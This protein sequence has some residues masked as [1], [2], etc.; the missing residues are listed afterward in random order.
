MQGTKKLLIDHYNCYNKIK[1]EVLQLATTRNTNYGHWKSY[2]LLAMA[3]NTNYGSLKVATCCGCTGSG[4]TGM[5]PVSPTG[6]PSGDFDMSTVPGDLQSINGHTVR[7]FNGVVKSDQDKCDYRFL[8]LENGLQALLISEPGLDKASAALDVHVGNFY[9]PEDIPGLAHFLEHLLFMGT[10]KYPD[11]NEYGKYLSAH[12]GHSN[13]FTAQEHTN[14]FFDVVSDHL[15]GALDRFAQF[16]ISPLFNP[17]GTERE[18]LAVDSEHKKNVLNDHWRIAQLEK[19]LS[20]HSHPYSHFGTGSLKTLKEGP[21]SRGIDIRSVLIEFYG[22]HY[23]SNLMKLVVFGKNPLDELQ[24]MVVEKFSAVGNRNFALR[25]WPGMPLDERHFGKL[26]NVRTVKEMRS[27]HVSWQLPDMKKYKLEKPGHYFSH[28]LGHEGHGSILAL[29][30]AQGWATHLS[31]GADADSRGYTFFEVAIELSSS[32]LDHVEDIVKLIFQYLQL[33]RNS[34]PQKAIFEETKRLEEIEFRF[35]EKGQPSSFA[36]RTSGNMQS[37]APELILKGPRVSMKYDEGLLS[38]MLNHIRG[39]NFRIILATPSPLDAEKV[40]QEKWYKTEY[41]VEPLSEELMKFTQ[42]PTTNP[43]LVLPIPN[44]F[45][46]DALNAKMAA[47]LIP[48]MKPTLIADDGQYRL[49]HKQDD[50]FEMPKGCFQ[51]VVLTPATYSSP[52][53]FVRTYLFIELLRDSMN[54]LLYEAEM[55]GLHFD[56]GQTT[57]GIYLAFCGYDQKLPLLLKEVMNRVMQYKTNPARFAAIKDKYARW[58]KSVIHDNPYGLIAYYLNGLQLEYNWWYWEK[59]AALPLITADSIDAFAAEIFSRA[60]IEGLCHGNY[61]AEEALGIFT[62]LRKILSGTKALPELETANVRVISLEPRQDIIFSPGPIPNSNSAI[63]FYLQI[64][65]VG[66]LRLRT[67]TILFAQIFH[68][69]FFDLLRTKEQLGYI[70]RHQAREK[71]NSIGLRFLVQSE[72]DPVYLDNRIEVFLSNTVEYLTSMDVD[73]YSTHV[74]ALIDRLTA[75]KR[76]MTDE[77][78]VYWMQIIGHQYEFERASV[79]ADYLKNHT[80]EDLLA[81][82]RTHVLRDAPER[83]KLSI[84]LWSDTL[85][86]KRVVAYSELAP[87]VQLFEEPSKLTKAVGLFPLTYSVDDIGKEAVMGA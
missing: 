71:G 17:S 13:A 82:I 83:R 28:L 56:I 48:T 39:D 19:T 6:M 67:L 4:V 49:W 22:K 74:R 12:G 41:T 44:E 69:P 29:L 21:E 68:E 80:K 20:S 24:N 79:D 66:S 16:F 61:R 55:A 9:D 23:S 38:T 54:E 57:D 76:R 31:A 46:P 40:Q 86:D 18:L 47:A 33:L 14:Y 26:I 15:E 30:K 81:F 60:N 53:N 45:I 42:S 73:E 84:Q 5:A 11:E 32:G 3:R 59:E 62:D 63:E 10:R 72:R 64:G 36:S 1:H 37:Y 25:E 51:F 52:E 75:K 8:T 7:V 77:T 27:M 78:Q 70:V 35:M 87:K 58:L 50:V 34:G 43:D 85:A 65:P 2:S